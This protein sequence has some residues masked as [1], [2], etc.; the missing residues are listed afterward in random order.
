MFLSKKFLILWN[1][2][3]LSKV[4]SGHPRICVSHHKEG[5]C[6]SV[7][8]ID[9]CPGPPHYAAGMLTLPCCRYAD[10]TVGMEM[11]NTVLQVCPPAVLQVCP[12]HPAAGMPTPPCCRHCTEASCLCSLALT[13]YTSRNETKSLS[14]RNISK[15]TD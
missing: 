15:P 1:I 7:L 4:P 10:P 5:A 2:P 8:D 11:P 9:L 14:S 12:P 13:A 3:V 6:V